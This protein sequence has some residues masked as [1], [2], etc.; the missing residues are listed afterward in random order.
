MNNAEITPETETET[1]DAPG[2]LSPEQLQRVSALIAARELL[3][4][5]TFFAAKTTAAP[6]DLIEVATFI[7]EG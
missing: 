7:L 2:A 1:A 5:T 3:T 4:G 6:S